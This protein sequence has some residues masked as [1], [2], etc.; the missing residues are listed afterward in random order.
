MRAKPTDLDLP[1]QEATPKEVFQ[2][3]RRF[4]KALG[5]AGVS[6]GPWAALSRW[7]DTPAHAQGATLQGLADLRAAKDASFKLDRPLTERKVAATFNN[8]Y[9]FSSNKDVWKHV[10]KFKPMPW[11][12]SVSGLVEYPRTYDVAEFIA[13][14]PLEE[15]LYRFRCVEAWAMAVPWIGVPL[16]KIIEAAKPKPSARYVRFL[17]FLRPRQAPG[18][19]RWLSRANDLWPYFEAL[20]LP[21]ALND[22]ALLTVG[23]FGQELPKQHGAPVRVILPWKYGFKGIK[24]LVRIELTEKRPE[25]FWHAL[26]PDEYGFFSNVN[27]EKPHPRW[28]QATE[29]MLGTNEVHDTKLYNGYGKWVAHLYEG[30]SEK[31]PRFGFGKG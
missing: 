15:R 16:R 10:G 31:D 6:L 12:F 18:Q 20:T 27:P 26:A 8:F 14:Q 4:I 21:E 9:E 25:T 3:R 28:S 19:D 7:L 1:P 23:I 22:L 17:S 24:S 30:M 11:S 2:D 29:Y 13:S 5:L